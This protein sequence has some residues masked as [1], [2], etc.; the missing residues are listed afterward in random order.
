MY[1]NP[2]SLQDH[3]DSI[4]LMLKDYT[5][6]IRGDLKDI[7]RRILVSLITTDVHN[8]DI[9]KDLQDA[10]VQSVNEFDW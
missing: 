4:E 7:Q 8:R 6:L 5:S 3:L 9:V 2:F 1:A 10:S